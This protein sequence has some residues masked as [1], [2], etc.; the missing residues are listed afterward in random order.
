LKEHAEAVAEYERRRAADRQ[1]VNE[2][3]RARVMELATDFPRLWN[4][5]RTGHRDRKRMVRLLVEDATLIK[6]K[7]IMVNVRFKGGK[8]KTLKLER[9]KNSWEGWTTDSRVV[10]EIDR[11]LDHHTYG[12]IAAIL[13]ESG[14]ASGQGRRFDGRRVNRIR[15]SY[16][17][18]SR[19]ERLREKGFITARELA[20]KLGISSSCVRARRARGLIKAQRVYDTRQC[21]Y[22]DPTQRLQEE[23]NV[24][25]RTKGV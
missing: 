17:L 8:I 1:V 9:P 19:Y 18:K 25:E 5:P 24:A 10:E 21:L 2:E 13:N 6:G 22:E 11:L 4:D 23:H 14:V 16:G 7:M 3:T 20:D 12:E 15:R